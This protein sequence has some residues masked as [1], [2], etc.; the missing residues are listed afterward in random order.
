M[1]C[2]LILCF[3]GFL[4]GSA[5]SHAALADIYKCVDDS[6]HV[7]YSNVDKKGCKRMILDP[8]STI[9]T[10]PASAPATR[11]AVPRQAGTATASPSAFPRVDDD[12]QKRRDTDRR[13]ILEQE[14]SAEEKNLEQAKKD[15]TEQEAVRTGDER[16][17]Q[18][19]L[20]RLQPYKDR[21]AQHERNIESLKR[22]TAN[23]R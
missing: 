13:R 11:P 6:G 23:L 2:R 1:R 9:P 21:V 15:L 7:T 17:Y 20:D 19:V 18:R 12:T 22:E 5:T 16:N 3:T 10:G 4:L 8:I 14:L